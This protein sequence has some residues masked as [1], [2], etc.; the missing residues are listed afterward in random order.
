M[1]K[2]NWKQV[3]PRDLRD[4]L[5]LCTVYALEK[6][7]RSKDH[8]A[9]LMA[10]ESKWVL[11]KWISEANMP[12]RLVKTFEMACGIDLVSRWL[13]VSSGKL[14]ID[15]PKGKKCK[16]TDIQDLQ[17]VNHTAIGELIKFY[18]GEHNLEETLAAIQTSLESMAFHKGNVEKFQ[19]PELPF[20][21]D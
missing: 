1:A 6:H 15:I 19:Q 20:N 7:N 9:D 10:L 4:A 18:N 16:A 13:V 8:I 14:V 2:R 5:D 17:A 12:V 11:Y 21:E 3:Q